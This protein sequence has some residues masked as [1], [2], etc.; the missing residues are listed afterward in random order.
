M[1]REYPS[2]CGHFL[3]KEGDVYQIM[4]SFAKEYPLSIVASTQRV[5]HSPKVH[6]FGSVIYNA[7]EDKF[8]Q[9]EPYRNIEVVDRIGSGDAYIS[10]AL[11]GLLAHDFDCQKA[12]E[13]G[14]A[15]SAVKNTI[16]GLEEIDR[17]INNHKNT[18]VQLEMDR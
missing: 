4:R 11:Y 7:K 17:I 2:L 13:Y 5:V 10:G 16:P 1:Y 14:N 3:L 15:T 8:Y 18:G 9:E 6:T 12:L